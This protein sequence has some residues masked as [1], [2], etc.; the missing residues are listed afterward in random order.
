MGYRAD[1]YLGI[2]NSLLDSNYLGGLGQSISRCQASK[3][4]LELNERI[5]MVFADSGEEGMHTGI[6]FRAGGSAKATSYFQLRFSGPQ[7]ALGE[8]VG[9]GYGPV[10]DKSEYGGLILLESE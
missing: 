3:N 4:A 6:A 1:G 2:G 9:K 5:E 10:K 7:V 8:I